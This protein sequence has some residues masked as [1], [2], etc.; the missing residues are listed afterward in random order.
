MIK[1]SLI[2]LALLWVS[3][4]GI[5]IFREKIVELL[6]GSTKPKE[7][8][9]QEIPQ[10]VTPQPVKVEPKTLEV[11]P[12]EPLPDKP[13]APPPMLVK[14]VK[15][16]VIP[17]EKTTNQETQSEKVEKIPEPTFGLICT[18]YERIPSRFRLAS[19]E[20]VK[21]VELEDLSKRDPSSKKHPR[22]WLRVRVPYKE[23]VHPSSKESFFRPTNMHDRNKRLIVQSFEVKREALSYSALKKPIGYLILRDFKMGGSPFQLTSE[24]DSPMTSSYYLHFEQIMGPKKFFHDL[25][26]KRNGHKFGGWGIEYQVTN[27][28]FAQNKITVLRKDLKTL[29]L[30]KKDLSGPTSL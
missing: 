26:G 23:F 12:F 2:V 21:K 16:E 13:T 8:V 3:F 11:I 1:K 30:A 9:K 10:V 29:K 5:M 20:G 17:V 4:L 19:W 24:M 14:E 22:Y 18:K 27:Q 25:T 6:G 7:I 28:N 15:K